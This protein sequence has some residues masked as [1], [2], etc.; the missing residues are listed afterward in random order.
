MT[1]TWRGR[2][3]VIAVI[4]W[5]LPSA[6]AAAGPSLVPGAQLYQRSDDEFVSALIV[7]AASGQRLYAYLPTKKWPAASTTKLLSTLVAVER[8]P[9]W[10]KA[11]AMSKKDEVGGGHLR[12]DVGSRLTVRDLLYSSI[13]GSANNA[14]MALARS[15]GLTS[16]QF[17]KAMNDK[18]ASI[19]MASS[20][21]TDP[22]G[23]DPSNLTTA[24][25]LAKLAQYAF[26]NES[27]RRAASTASYRFRILNRPVTKQIVNTNRL[28][29]KDEDIW[30]LGGK[31]GFLYESRYN[32]VVKL[33][34]PPGSVR[35]PS[36]LVVV[37]GSP[38]KESS[39]DTAKSLAKWAWNAYDWSSQ[40]TVAKR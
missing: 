17:V 39:F 31:T 7:D 23:I 37:L 13:V 19:G 4:A 34:T 6:V 25:D 28:L 5:L 33:T 21:Y 26:S 18:A 9:S 10:N 38:A 14:A 36:L 2:T 27:I 35:K 40:S 24:S 8:K 12:V 30:V 1:R 22:A 16:K 29:T 32:L 11:V 20:T 15:T 3:Y